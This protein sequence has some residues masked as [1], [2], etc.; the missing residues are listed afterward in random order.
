L[1]SEALVRLL[2]CD[3]VGEDVT[4]ESIATPRDDI[5]DLQLR[6]KIPSAARDNCRIGRSTWCS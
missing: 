3:L 5:A 2:T 4:R 1:K 6:S